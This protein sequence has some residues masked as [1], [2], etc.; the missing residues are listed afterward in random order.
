MARKRYHYRHVPPTGDLVYF[1]L[2]RWSGEADNKYSAYNSIVVLQILCNTLANGNDIWFSKGLF[3]NAFYMYDKT[4]R[5][6]SF[7]A[8]FA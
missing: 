2:V 5:N 6:L 3:V 8:F 4:S 1:S 7:D